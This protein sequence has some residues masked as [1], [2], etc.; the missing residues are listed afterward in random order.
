MNRPLL[1][2]SGQGI[3]RSD[4]LSASLD[5]ANLRLPIAI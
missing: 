4:R 2:R 5:I 3:V 1:R